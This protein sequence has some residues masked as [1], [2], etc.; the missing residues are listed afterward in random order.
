MAM[1]PTDFGP[2]TFIREAQNL[3]FVDPRIMALATD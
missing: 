3:V 2:I 1:L